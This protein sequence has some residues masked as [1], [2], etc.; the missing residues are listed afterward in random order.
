MT[1]SEPPWLK[2]GTQILAPDA[3]TSALCWLKEQ[4]SWAQKALLESG[5]LLLRGFS[6]INVDEL[7][8]IATLVGGE[9]PQPYE[10][11]ST[12]RTSVKGNIYTSTEYPASEVIPLH[13]ENSYSAGWPAQILFLCE[14]PAQQDGE[15][16]IA[17]SR[18]VYTSISPETRAAFERKGVM[19]TRHYCEVGL[20]WQQ[21][22]HTD[23]RAEVEQYCHR[24]N[25]QFEWDAAGELSTR[26][27]LPACRRH[28]ITQQ[29]VWFNQAHL[30]HIS[31]LGSFAQDLLDIYGPQRVPR[32]A[33]FGDGS[34]IEIPLLDEI[35]AAYA[36]HSVPLAWS[37]NDLLILDNMLWAHGRRTYAGPRRILVAMT[38][39]IRDPGTAAL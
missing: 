5:A 38:R 7:E 20:S 19:Y 27:V 29:W 28:P 33:F 1:I 6:A 37:R 23:Q 14:Q 4:H 3:R 36:A 11:R 26:Q 8:A 12:P 9:R 10:N 31:N 17:D 2:G 25:I 32:N 35:R 34:E 13:N 30:F 39:M 15:T 22:F 24:N 16:P 21:T 18:K